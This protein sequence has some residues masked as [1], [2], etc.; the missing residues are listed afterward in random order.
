MAQTFNLDLN[1]LS[2]IV[3]VA[4]RSSVVQLSPP[5]SHFAGL[6]L[7]GQDFIRKNRMRLWVDDEV[8]LITYYIGKNCWQ[9][10]ERV[11]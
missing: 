11:A 8:G 6:N 5:N 1:E 3:K 9:K 7:L 4:G 2:W 10:P